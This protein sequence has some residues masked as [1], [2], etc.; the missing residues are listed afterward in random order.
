MIEAVVGAKVANFYDEYIDEE[1]WLTI[2][3]F[4][5]TLNSSTLKVTS[6]PYK[7]RFLKYTVVRRIIDFPI[8]LRRFASF[9]DIIGNVIDTSA[10]LG[11]HIFLI[12]GSYILWLCCACCL[13]ISLHCSF[14]F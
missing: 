11:K 6:H 5:V 9:S 1:E 8:T 2:N 7:I 13:K 14:F 10:L 3:H 12:F 4:G